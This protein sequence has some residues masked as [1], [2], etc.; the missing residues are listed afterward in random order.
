M[1]RVSGVFIV[2][3]FALIG[4]SW[5]FVQSLTEHEQQKQ[6]I[7]EKK[8]NSQISK[9]IAF[10]LKKNHKDSVLC[11]VKNPKNTKE[12]ESSVKE[13]TTRQVSPVQGSQVV[14]P[15]VVESKTQ[16]VEQRTNSVQTKTQQ[17]TAKTPPTNNQPDPAPRQQIEIP[18]VPEVKV[19]EVKVPKVEMPKVDVPKVDDVLD[20]VSAASD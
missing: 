5:P 19:P 8:D 11:T 7:V 6:T 2:L 15:I 9:V 16:R 14:R 1:K 12:L 4:L 3:A 17:S 10:C 20:K 13:A 18:K